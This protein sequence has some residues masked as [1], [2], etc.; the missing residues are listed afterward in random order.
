VGAHQ[1]PTWYG[2]GKLAPVAT[3]LPRVAIAS[4]SAV[5]KTTKKKK[6]IKKI[7]KN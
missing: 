3:V 2:I 5:K 7:K 1:A 4:K 6:K